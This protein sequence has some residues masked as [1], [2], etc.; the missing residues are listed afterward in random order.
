MK[1]PLIP[2]HTQDDFAKWVLVSLKFSVCQLN[3]C[4]AERGNVMLLAVLT[5]VIF[6]SYGLK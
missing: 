6:F 2:T 5:L 4:R 1:N 3:W